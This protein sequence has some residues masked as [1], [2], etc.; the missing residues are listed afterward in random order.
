MFIWVQ[1]HVILW[2]I[3]IYNI[4]K[5]SSQSNRSNIINLGNHGHQR[6]IDTVTFVTK[7]VINACR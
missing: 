5:P 3:S 2:A 4:N 6:N 7:M 1:K